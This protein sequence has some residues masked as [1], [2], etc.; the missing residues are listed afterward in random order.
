[1][2]KTATLLVLVPLVL[3]IALAL[4][5][6]THTIGFYNGLNKGITVGGCG[7]EL[8]GQPGPFCGDF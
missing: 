7:F 6:A 4:G 3:A 1:M 8:V 2:T 5:L